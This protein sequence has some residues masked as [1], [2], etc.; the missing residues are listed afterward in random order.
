MLK[1]RRYLSF[2]IAAF[3]VIAMIFLAIE[4][5]SFK[6]P[7][8]GFHSIFDRRNP[9]RLPSRAAYLDYSVQDL[10]ILLEYLIQ[11]KYWFLS[12]QDLYDYFLIE[13][14]TIPEKHIGRRPVMLTFDD[15]Y[16]NIHAFV[17]PL[18]EKLEKKY[19]LK[20]PIVLFLNPAF[21]ERKKNKGKPEYLNCDRVKEGFEKGFYDVQ[22]AGVNHTNL[23]KLPTSDLEFE[24]LESQKQLQACIAESSDNTVALH[25]GYPYNRVNRKVA[26][27]TSQYYRSGYLYN[28]EMFKINIFRNN[29]R[30]SRWGVFRGDSPQKLINR[31]RKASKIQPQ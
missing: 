14:K 12:S 27:S 21:M 20:I 23:T 11:E 4:A 22:S 24:L 1:L 26:F 13:S 5:I 6:I 31:A 2:S 8:F 17:L 25:F 28:D 10:E 29:Y 18:L 30:I 3:L 15:G 9:E 16:E 7:I 19:N